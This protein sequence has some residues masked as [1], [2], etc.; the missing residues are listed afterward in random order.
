MSLN[1]IYRFAT[2]LLPNPAIG[3]LTL[4]TSGKYPAADRK[5]LLGQLVDMIPCFARL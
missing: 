3:I 4:V 1:R 5:T 2:I